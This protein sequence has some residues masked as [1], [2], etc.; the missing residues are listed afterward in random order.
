MAKK[1]FIQSLPVPKV[2]YDEKGKP[3]GVLL[4]TQ[5]YEKLIEL[6]EDYRDCK[7][8]MNIKPDRSKKTYSQ[9]E[10][11]AELWGK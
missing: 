9:E 6:V 7:F 5:G 3:V 10:V 4:P 8:M 2:L 1:T 11:A